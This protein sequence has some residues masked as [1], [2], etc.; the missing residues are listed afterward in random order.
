MVDMPI[1]KALAERLEKIAHSERRP[2]QDVLEDMVN[3]YSPPEIEEEPHNWPLLMAQLAETHEDIQW[4]DEAEN[5]S[6]N[7][8]T[9]LESHFADSLIR[10]LHDDEPDTYG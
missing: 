4:T 3:T 7:M 8:R 1:T 9:I 5:L 2:L 10:R 6:E